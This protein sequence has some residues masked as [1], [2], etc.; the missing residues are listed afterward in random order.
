[1]TNNVVGMF[2]DKSLVQFLEETLE[3][4]RKGEVTHMVSIQGSEIST[5]YAVIGLGTIKEVTEMIGNLQ[6]V[7]TQL[8]LSV[9]D[10]T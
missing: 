8:T 6:I 5:S 7:Q 10:E 9:M 3:Q 2:S 4:A 1:M